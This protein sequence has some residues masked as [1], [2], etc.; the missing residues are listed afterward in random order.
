MTRE[1]K[2]FMVATCERCNGKESVIQTL[3]PVQ[4][5]RSF[6]LWP[7]G[8][9]EGWSRIAS[10]DLCGECTAKVNQVLSGGE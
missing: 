5:S 4:D 10:R 1:Y 6:R 7:S 2:A 9:P 8:L 3:E